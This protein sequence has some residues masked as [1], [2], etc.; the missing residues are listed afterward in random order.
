MAARQSAAQE[1]TGFLS[2]TPEGINTD[3]I[4]TSQIDNVWLPFAGAFTG[5]PAA[6]LKQ[7]VLLKSTKDSQLVDG[8]M[9]NLSAESVIKDFKP[10]GT[11]YALA[12]RLTGKFKTAFPDGK[13]EDKK[14]EEKKDGEK[15]ADE[16]PAE[17]KPTIRSR[18]RSRTTPSSWSATRT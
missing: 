4:V 12:V 16:K 3:D 8:F 15:K 5:T 9:A 18:K 17:K 13:P 1:A 10:S 14:D 2:I 6:G 7:T 11:E